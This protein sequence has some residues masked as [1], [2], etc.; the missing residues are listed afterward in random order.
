MTDKCF[1]ANREAKMALSFGRCVARAFDDTALVQRVLANPNDP[2]KGDGGAQ[3][4]HALGHGR[5]AK[6]IGR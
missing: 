3:A 5:G 6:R 4:G 1:P 2:Y